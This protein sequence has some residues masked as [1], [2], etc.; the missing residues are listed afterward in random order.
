M[1]ITLSER[2]LS[3]LIRQ[4]ENITDS[5]EEICFRMVHYAE[6]LFKHISEFGVRMQGMLDHN[7]GIANFQFT[8]AGVGKNWQTGDFDW[9]KLRQGLNAMNPLAVTVEPEDIDTI[10]SGII[11]VAM[12][13]NWHQY[14]ASLERITVGQLQGAIENACQ[15]YAWGSPIEM[16]S[17]SDT[18]ETMR[19]LAVQDVFARA[20]V[21]DP[22]LHSRAV[23]SRRQAEEDAYQAAEQKRKNAWYQQY[24]R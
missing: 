18:D 22:S 15:K 5:D 12:L 21:I 20:G 24:N 8:I 3:E 9:D 2:R 23:K 7:G 1:V 17:E 11:R 14:A 16:G 4:L 6:R 19:E 10:C 13:D